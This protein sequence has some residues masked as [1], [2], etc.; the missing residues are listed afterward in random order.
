MFATMDSVISKNFRFHG[1]ASLK[2]V[3]AHGN[4]AR[5]RWFAMKYLANP[6]RSRPRLAVVVSKKVFK[7]AVQRNRVRR[8]VYEIARPFIVA[9][10]Q[11]ID[12]AISVYSPEILTAPHDELAK[13]LLP[14]LHRAGLRAGK[15]I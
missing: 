14:L 8:R 13:Q 6:R 10:S 5:G 15:N 12:V 1:H 9:T 7:S 4:A 11:P 2:Y 3:F